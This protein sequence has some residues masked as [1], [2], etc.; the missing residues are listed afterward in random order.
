ME[1][2][3]RGA[4]YLTRLFAE[5]LIQYHDIEI[6]TTCAKSYHTWENEYPEGIEV[7]NDVP[8]DDLRT[9]N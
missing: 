5:H 7:I 9:E 6:L 8:S 2:Y 4:E 3:L 1:R